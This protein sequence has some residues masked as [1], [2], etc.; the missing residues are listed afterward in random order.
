MG[1]YTLSHPQ[2]VATECDA[3]FFSI[4]S[5]DLVSKYQGE[6]ERLV[7]TLF[8]MAREQ[9]PSIVFID[10]I[11][12]LASARSDQD[13]DSTRRIKTELLVQMQGVGKDS[14]GVLVLGATNF[15]QN[16][17]SAVRRRFEK[18]IYIGLPEAHAR[19]TILE[20]NLGS[21]P[22]SLSADDFETL[23]RG[24]EGFSGSDIAILMKGALMEPIRE[25]QEASFFRMEDGK[26]Y[27]CA[28]NAPG[29]VELNLSGIKGSELGT[30]KV[31][32]DHCST[33]LSHMHPSVCQGDIDAL[34]EWANMFG[35]E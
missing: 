24:T 28:S 26:Y 14:E 3:T 31:N 20:L 33:A 22:N 27:A 12:S 19:R 9:A 5:S 11:D 1:P 30:P 13:S 15:P 29:A 34:L 2:A 17:D 35:S 18:R 7:K 10:E 8:S 4:S 32:V 23:A 21:T 25:L 6:S 16:L